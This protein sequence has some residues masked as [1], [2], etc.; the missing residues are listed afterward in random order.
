MNVRRT[1]FLLTILVLIWLLRPGQVWSESK[2][3]W[4]QRELIL[5]TLVVIVILYFAYGL[6][7]LYQRGWFSP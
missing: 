3:M 1:L 7:E 2:R 6:Y 4:T 5:R